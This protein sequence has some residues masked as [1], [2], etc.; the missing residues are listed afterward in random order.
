M[1][2]ISIIDISTPNVGPVMPRTSQWPETLTPAAIHI[3]LSLADEDRHGLGIVGEVEQRT[4]GEV[5]LGPGILY[6]TIKRMKASGLIAELDR[7][8]GCASDDPRRRYYQITPLGR[9]SLRKETK[10]ME[11]IVHTARRKSVLEAADHR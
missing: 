11:R 3:L 7:A 2:D 5:R 1:F 9:E 6:G 4:D 10:R 8:S